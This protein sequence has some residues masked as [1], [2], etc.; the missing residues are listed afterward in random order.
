MGCDPH[1]P[2]PGL[3]SLLASWEQGADTGLG[4]LSA[5]WFPDVS[6]EGRASLET[7]R[8]LWWSLVR[9]L[10][11]QC[12]GVGLGTLVRELDPTCCVVWPRKEDKRKETLTPWDNLLKF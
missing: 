5:A 9:T 7:L 3:T 12:G 11:F 1:Q 2:Q 6:K 10:C 8:L 4:M